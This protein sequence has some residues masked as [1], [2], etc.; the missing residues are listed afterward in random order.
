MLFFGV[1]VRLHKSLDQAKSLG[2]GRVAFSARIL[3]EI[4]Q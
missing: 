1:P 4:K 3:V 2:K